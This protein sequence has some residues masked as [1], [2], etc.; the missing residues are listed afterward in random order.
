MCILKRIIKWVSYSCNVSSYLYFQKCNVSNILE[1]IPD[2]IQNVPNDID[3][4]ATCLSTIN[5]NDAASMNMDVSIG[6][7]FLQQFDNNFDTSVDVRQEMMG[8]AEQPLES[9]S[10]VAVINNGA[11]LSILL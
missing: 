4:D 1:I 8:S 6:A 10:Q 3:S 11:Y 2:Q 5:A 9:T 7:T